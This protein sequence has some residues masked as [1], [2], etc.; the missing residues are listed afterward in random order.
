MF[1]KWKYSLN[2]I[3][4]YFCLFQKTKW[5]YLGSCWSEDPLP[6][7]GMTLSRLM[8]ALHTGQVCL[9][10]LVSSHWWRHGQLKRGI[11]I[12]QLQLSKVSITY[13]KNTLI[14]YRQVMMELQIYLFIKIIW[15]N[16]FLSRSQYF[17]ENCHDLQKRTVRLS[18][19]YCPCMCT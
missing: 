19:N 5:T 12:Y 3:W 2:T 18:W 6:Y 15:V 16:F 17:C 1:N 9:F 13:P 8:P 14:I 4:C 11:R 10:G 7:T